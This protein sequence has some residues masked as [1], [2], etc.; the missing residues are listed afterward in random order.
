MIK[1]KEPISEGEALDSFLAELDEGSAVKEIAGWE[2]GFPGLSRLLNGIF[3]GLYLLIGPPACGKTTFA[4]QLCD[5]VA[6]RNSIPAIF[7]AFIERK[8]DLRIRTLARLSGLENREIRRGSAFLLHWYGMPKPRSKDPE[9]MPPSWEKLKK[10]TEGARSW[11]DLVYIF[12]GGEKTDLEEVKDCIRRVREIKGSQQLL[13]IIDDSQRLAPSEHAFDARLALVAERLQGLAVSHQ[14]AVIATWPDLRKEGVSYHLSPW[15]WAERVV[16]ADT[17]LVMENDVE[18]TKRLTEPNRAVTL[19]VAK[20]KDGE[21][22]TVAFD[23]FPAVARFL[24]A[25]SPSP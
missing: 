12:E 16:S 8:K 14:V 17:V 2:S 1:E 13:V 15:E 22:G 19:H 6:E 11:L 10:A 3:P 24:E 9:Q 5:Q 23:Y 21:R 18:R 4:K 25:P 20:N 7:F